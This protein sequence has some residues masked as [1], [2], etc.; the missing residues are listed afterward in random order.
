MAIIDPLDMPMGKTIVDPFEAQ[1]DVEAAKAVSTFD[2]IANQAK[3]GLTDSAVLGQAILD[4]FLIEPVTGLV[5]GKGK[6]GGIG[7]RFSENVKRLQKT[8]SELTGAT[9]GM[10]APGTV[11]EI[12][13]GGSRMMTDPINY[14]G[15]GP[16]MKTGAKLTDWA[17][18]TLAKTTGRAGGLFTLG[19]TAETGGMLGEQVEKTITG[20]TTGTGKAVGSLSAAVLGI[21]PA[22]AIEQAV[23]GAG[24]VAKQI[25]NKYKMVKT[26]PASANEAYASGAAKRLL[27]KIAQDLPA[28]QKIDDI[29]TEFNRISGIINKDKVPLAVAMSD[30]AL[31]K[32]Q[33]QKLAKENPQF[34]QRVDLELQNIATAIDD[35]SNFLFGPRY[36]PVTGAQGIDISNAYKRRQ[37][38]DDQI[39][40]LSSKFVPTEKQTEIGKAI[41]NLVEVRRKTAAAEISPTYQKI[42]DDATAAKAELPSDQVAS[43][44]RFVEE[45]NLRDIFGRNTP[46]DRQILSRLSPTQEKSLNEL[47]E[48]VAKDV[49]KPLSFENVDSLKRAINEFQRERLTLDESRRINQLENFVNDAR[50]SIPGDYSQRLADVDR[51]FYEKVGIP[52]SA[53]GIKDIDSKRYA[54]QVAPVII[55]N[56]SS[57]NQFLG[58]VGNQ[59]I[60]IA[61][62]A[63]IAEV[64]NK[65]IKNDVLDSRALRNYIKQKS[66]VLEQLPE[67][68]SLL[69]QA[70]LDD[71]ALR[72]ARANI[73]DAV[74]IAEKKVAD[75]FVISVKDSNGVSVP[76][77]IEISNKLFTDPNFFA[78]ITRDL[79]DLDPATS[80]AVYNSIRAEIVNK[81][82]DFPDGGLKFLADPKNSKVINQMFGKGYQASVKDLVKLSDSIRKAN[83]DDI[84]AVL[85]RAELDLVNKKLTELGIPGLD[86]PFITSTFRDRIA[87]IP[88]KIVRLAT[89]VNT[90]Q[91]KDA[92]DKAIGD[93]LL[94]KDGLEK[95]MNVA[96]TMDF[97]INNPTNFRK[98]KDSLSSVAPRYIY[99]GAKEA[100]MENIQPE[101]SAPQPQLDF[102]LFQ[103]QQ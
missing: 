19:T 72:L 62:N 96:R 39:E 71:G 81:A 90:A 16:V 43:I 102:T 99:G 54:E 100:I 23:S 70:L 45:N 50:K 10:K 17:A 26:D 5:T 20:E 41:E 44:Y 76:N 89:R 47:G 103:E 11:S 87:S 13:G 18:E 38:I 22:A 94:D 93:L 56:S 40:N 74:K 32:S 59:G 57:L 86:A 92:T 64:Y 28:D 68:K 15:V 2:Y 21:T 27:E 80:K 83:V 73:D 53:Q 67:T 78:K 25:Y 55:K 77:Y 101:P 61:N 46:I 69:N 66:S 49:F 63:V 97:K 33:I 29:V 58:A 8:A 31:V 9:T 75:N 30:N 1:P 4:T 35:R 34:R 84:S 36:A 85:M 79:K 98:L 95:L 7:E 65:A 52:F 51:V 14:I 42:I 60:P 82:R 6:K 24:N 3:L 48:E 88:Q 91:L 37:A 12:V